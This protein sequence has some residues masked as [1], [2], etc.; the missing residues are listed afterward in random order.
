MTKR[1]T[2]EQTPACEQVCQVA[3]G[4]AQRDARSSIVYFL[5]RVSFNHLSTFLT[6]CNIPVTSDLLMKY[7][8]P[9]H[10]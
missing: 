1:E 2:G 7:K 6:L 5:R 4:N 3:G 9:L 8:Y 10:L